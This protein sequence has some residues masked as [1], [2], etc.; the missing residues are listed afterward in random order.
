M[1]PVERECAGLASAFISGQ[2]NLGDKEH[3]ELGEYLPAELTNKRNS[4]GVCCLLTCHILKPRTSCIQHALKEEGWK[5]NIKRLLQ[6]R[7]L[8]LTSVD[9]GGGNMG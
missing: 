2:E 9:G 4:G 6:W 5:L 7:F 1:E 8:F 3:R